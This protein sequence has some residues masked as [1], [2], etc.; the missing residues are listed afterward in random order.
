LLAAADNEARRN[1]PEVS[2]AYYERALNV[3][4]AAGNRAAADAVRARMAGPRGGS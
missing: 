2:R 1:R 4:T 3:Y